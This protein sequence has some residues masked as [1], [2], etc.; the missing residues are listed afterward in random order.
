MTKHLRRALTGAV[1]AG[2]ALALTACGSSGSSSPVVGAADGSSAAPS[3]ASSAAAQAGSPTDGLPQ[4]PKLAGWLLPA[5]DLPKLKVDPAGTRNSGDGYSP[6]TPI[7]MS[8]T[9]SCQALGG[10]AWVAAGG[11]GS[12]AFAQSDYQ[13]AYGDEFAEEI[14]AFEG[15][16]ATTVM[17]R[18]RHVFAECGTFK[19]SVDGTPA[20]AKLRFKTLAGVGDQ[21]LEATITL[22]GYNGGTTLVATRVGKL[23]VTT[24]YN[25][26]RTTGG[27]GVTLTRRLVKGVPATQA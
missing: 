9:E 16:G 4:G 5:K 12:A 6:P 17:A 27:V 22:P 3:T 23:V 2:A 20:T 13:D 26:Q 11:L 10:T 19:L 25:D 8:K 1:C 7:A 14:D 24:F 15:T 21:S 18:L